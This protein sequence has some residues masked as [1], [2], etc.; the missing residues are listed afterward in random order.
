MCSDVLYPIEEQVELFQKLSNAGEHDINKC[1]ENAPVQVGNTHFLQVKNCIT[2]YFRV[3][4]HLLTFI[5]LSKTY[6]IE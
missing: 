3:V 4:I 6:F 5:Y 1:S 2:Q